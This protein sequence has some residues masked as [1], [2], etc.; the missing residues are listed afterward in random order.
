MPCHSTCQT[1]TSDMMDACQSCDTAGPNPNLYAGKCV[2]ACPSENFYENPTTKVCE[3]CYMDCLTCDGGANTDCLSCDLTV[4][5]KKYLSRSGYCSSSCATTGEY[6]DSNFHCH[7]C[8]S[9]CKQC[10]GPNNDQC[11][12]CHTAGTFK[13]LHQGQCLDSCPS[14]TISNT[15]TFVCE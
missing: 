6:Y 1:C 11:T 3:A 9:N 5:S 14:P 13:H 4:P 2:T 15:I 7:L 10:S 12:E 8:D